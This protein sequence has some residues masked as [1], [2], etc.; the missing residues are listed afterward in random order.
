MDVLNVHTNGKRNHT[1][2]TPS[3]AIAVNFRSRF[4]STRSVWYRVMTRSIATLPGR[5]LVSFD[6][7]LGTPRILASF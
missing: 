6:M 3:V 1:S 4:R 7:G 5:R 2:S